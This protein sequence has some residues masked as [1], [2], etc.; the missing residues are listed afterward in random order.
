MSG[1][2]HGLGC[3]TACQPD[4]PFPF[5]KPNYPYGHVVLGNTPERFGRLAKAAGEFVAGDP[6]RP[7]AIFVNAW[8]EWT[9]GSYLLPEEKYGAAYLKA[10]KE[11]LGRGG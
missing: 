5:P 9:E 1:G 7:P 11:A 10:L 3:D 6:K 4:I 8:N 2:D